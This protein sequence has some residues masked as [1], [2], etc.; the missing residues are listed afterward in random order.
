M[1]SLSQDFHNSDIFEMLGDFF[2][3]LPELLRW[4]LESALPS[5]LWLIPTALVIA[6]LVFLKLN[7]DVI[8]ERKTAIREI[9]RFSADIKTSAIKS[10]FD[11]SDKPD[12]L[13]ITPQG[14]RFAIKFFHNTKKHMNICLTGG[15][16]ALISKNNI[17]IRASDKHTKSIRFP[18]DTV[19]AD[20]QKIILLSPSA[21]KLTYVKPN[22]E[23]A[24][25]RDGDT[26][27]GVRFATRGTL[28]RF[29]ES[30]K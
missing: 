4:L 26:V 21:S 10:I 28:V 20:Y 17:D 16:N 18:I 15:E 27:F 24:E 3:S 13:I 25:V 5:L 7:L 30:N 11:K 19:S 6:A 2:G 9:S 8:M 14:K 23:V 29:L 22:G 12:I 1:F